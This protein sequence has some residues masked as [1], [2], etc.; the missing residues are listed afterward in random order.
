MFRIYEKFNTAT[1]VRYLDEL[2]H[3]YGRILVLMDGAAPLQSD[4]GLSG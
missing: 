3:K 2:R 1:F 4:N